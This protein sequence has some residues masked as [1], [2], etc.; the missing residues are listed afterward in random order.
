MVSVLVLSGCGSQGQPAAPTSLTEEA[1]TARLV[2]PGEFAAVVD[3]P[4]RVT[5]NVHVPFEG[6]IAGTDLSIPFDQIRSEAGRLP[7]DRSTGLAIYCRTG[8]MSTTA[9]Q[10]LHDL[11]YTDIVEL[12]GGMRAWQADGRRL[13]GLDE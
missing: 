4:H 5:I 11:G 3:E 6:D 2:D 10:T 9:A 12:R 8:P 1:S 13:I 7:A